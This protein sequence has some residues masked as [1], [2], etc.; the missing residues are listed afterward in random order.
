MSL[1]TKMWA[2]SA[3]KRRIQLVVLTVTSLS[4]LQLE[5]R[6]ELKLCAGYVLAL[7]RIGMH[8]E[9]HMKQEHMKVLAVQNHL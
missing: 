3:P 6:N 2:A 7:S 5:L 4:L 8:K 1:Y 9:G